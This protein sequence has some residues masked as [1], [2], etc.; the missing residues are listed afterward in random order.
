[1][2]PGGVSEVETGKGLWDRS[3]EMGEAEEE[4]HSAHR[5]LSAQESNL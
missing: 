1:M 2:P 3:L 5:S 4:R